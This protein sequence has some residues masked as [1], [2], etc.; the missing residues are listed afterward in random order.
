M[1]SLKTSWVASCLGIVLVS[2]PSLTPYGK[3][4]RAFAAIG[5]AGNAIALADTSLASGAVLGR[6]LEYGS[7]DRP[8]QV[9]KIV[10]WRL[11]SKKVA[12]EDA[13]KRTFCP[14][15]TNR[16]E[17]WSQLPEVPEVDRPKAQLSG[18]HL[19]GRLANVVE[20]IFNWSDSETP[21]GASFAS[22]AIDPPA[23]LQTP[24]PP[25]AVSF[26]ECLV[27]S[28]LSGTRRTGSRGE[29]ISHSD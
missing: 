4:N 27:F 28:H 2:L 9:V 22:V 18:L 25:I 6:S 10:P 21:K 12:W 7:G 17:Q 20:S 26:G 24:S 16:T 29:R 3:G 11:A 13:S 23:F 8:H 15:S 5:N 14:V 19:R 1:F